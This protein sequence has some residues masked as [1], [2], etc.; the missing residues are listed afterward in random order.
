M[1]DQLRR[2]SVGLKKVI[3]VRVATPTPVRGLLLDASTQ[4][5]V[6]IAQLRKHVAILMRLIEPLERH[7]AAFGPRAGFVA[8]LDKGPQTKIAIELVADLPDQALIGFV[9]A[10]LIRLLGGV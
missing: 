2:C 10:G 9:Q 4:G 7:W 8:L 5:M 3:R 1:T 6:L